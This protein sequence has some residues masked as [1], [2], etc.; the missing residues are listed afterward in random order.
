MIL[1][2]Q[3]E[4]R[5]RAVGTFVN[6]PR[7]INPATGS[8]RSSAILLWVL[9][10]AGLFLRAFQLFAQFSLNHDDICIAL[11]ILGRDWA[12]LAHTLDYDQAA[13]LAF[14]WIEHAV[15]HAGNSELILQM[16]PFLFCCASLCLFAVLAREVLSPCAAVLTTGFFAASLS[17]A[18]SGLQVKPY[19]MDVLA[20]VI[21]TLLLFRLGRKPE[22]NSM[23]PTIIVCILMWCSFP[24]IFVLAGAL[25]VILVFGLFHW[26]G[27]P[28]RS[29]FP[30]I[31]VWTICASANYFFSIRP[32][33]SNTRL[34]AMDSA[35]E[36][37]VHAPGETIRASGEFL[38]NLGFNATSTHLAIV[39]GGALIIAAISAFWRR[40]LI[41][42][43]MLAPIPLCLVASALQR[44]PLFPRM[45][46]FLTPLVLLATARELGFLAEK[47]G[48]RIQFAVC[49]FV[50]LC[51]AFSW[52]SSIRNGIVHGSGFDDPRGATA[53][54]RSQWHAGDQ[55][56]A[57]YA[58]LPAANYYGVLRGGLM[59]ADIV[60]PRI[61]EFTPGAAIAN[62]PVPRSGRVW[63]LYFEPDE[64]GFD[65]QIVAQYKLAGRRF[66]FR[67][68]KHYTAARWQLGRN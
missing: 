12:A 3:F 45:I 50:S 16:A 35:A 5:Q 49:C 23:A 17:L 59:P 44:Y 55:L 63:F 68:F 20:C 36:L 7:V 65:K 19:S 38:I 39:A 51:V 6:R 11:N 32:G 46:L 41:S 14:L 29:W 54:I 62:N 8:L 67:H 56:Y 42:I 64:T 43:Q 21:I 48:G 33:L 4:D 30:M 40:D 61:P 15:A 58:G 37:P 25:C 26:N 52:V 1:P 24:A 31:A 22:I 66:E 13:P 60:S 57:S 27:S 9:V 34:A 28:S 18:S 47:F 2:D 10:L 53:W